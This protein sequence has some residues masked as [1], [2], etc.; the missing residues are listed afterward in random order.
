MIEKDKMEMKDWNTYYFPQEVREQAQVIKNCIA[1][2]EKGI[3]EFSTKYQDIKKVQIIGSGDCYFISIAAAEAFRSLAKVEAY[4]YEAY[5]YCLEMPEV[6]NETIVILFSSS[7]KSLYVLKAL[8]YVKSG[9]G[10][11]LG[12]TNHKDSPLGE[13]SSEVF[14]TDSIGVSRTFPTKTTT[15]ALAIMY[16]L[17]YAYAAQKGAVTET[18]LEYLDDELKNKVPDVIEKILIEETGRI[19]NCAQRFLEARC[20]T[21]VG[22]GPCRSAALVGA[23]KIVE[24]SRAHVT[25]CNAEEYMHLHGFSIKSA[26]AVIIIGNN[27]SSHREIQVAE[28]ANNQCA[29][30]FIVGDVPCELE[31]ENCVCVAPYLKELSEWGNSICSMVVLQIFACELSRLS[32][33][34][35]DAPHDVDL[36]KVIELLYTG[37]VAGWGI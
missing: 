9:G 14:V 4:G 26:D 1:D 5:D 28:Y 6:D 13:G 22:S 3:K 20:Y 35:P 36:K 16:R 37:P 34:D 7:G 11:S 21:Y 19:K 32:F 27:K 8:E 24:T 29:R 30:V 10:I 12:V 2:L 25:F 15:S 18:R 23:A 31:S 17:A 33:K